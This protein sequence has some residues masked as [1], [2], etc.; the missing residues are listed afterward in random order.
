MRS[1]FKSDAE[2]LFEPFQSEYVSSD[3][4]RTEI[5]QNTVERYNLINKFLT[6]FDNENDKEFASFLIVQMIE[7]LKSDELAE[8]DRMIQ[9]VRS[10]VNQSSQ[11]G[12]ST[13]KLDILDYLA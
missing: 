11:K 10:G 5:V 12:T 1:G 8:Y 2:A 9:F 13:G 7:S 3:A 4:I 6:Q